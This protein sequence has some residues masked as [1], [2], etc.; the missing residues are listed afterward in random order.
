MTATPT[1]APTAPS[2]RCTLSMVSVNWAPD[3]TA[4]S[5]KTRPI[6]LAACL[7][8]SIPSVVPL[9]S[10]ISSLPE[11][12]NNS[13]ASLAFSVPFSI[14]CKATTASLKTVSWS[15]TAPV[16]SLTLM[17]SVFIMSAPLPVPVTAWS[18][19]LVSFFIPACMTSILVPF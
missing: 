15:F 5:D 19:T 18:I 1:L 9:S 8:S 17:P 7:S 10:G 4:S 16:E 6:S 13:L 12:P 11:P 3:A 2:D 14:P